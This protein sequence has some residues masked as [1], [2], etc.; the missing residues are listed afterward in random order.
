MTEP[1]E[2]LPC[3]LFREKLGSRLTERSIR[4]LRQAWAERSGNSNAKSVERV[5]D[6]IT[7]AGDWSK[8]GDM[9]EILLRALEIAGGE[10]T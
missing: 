10:D 4:C 2:R 9:S 5:V 6:Q 8:L 7:E 1:R 3:D